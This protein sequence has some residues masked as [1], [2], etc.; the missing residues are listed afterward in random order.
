MGE[1]SAALLLLVAGAGAMVVNIVLSRSRPMASRTTNVEWCLRVIA[2]VGFC[3][4]VLVRF[5]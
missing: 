3:G 1:R 4:F 5:A 2:F